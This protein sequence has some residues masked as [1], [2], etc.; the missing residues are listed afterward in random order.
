MASPSLLPVA[1]PFPPPRSLG[2]TNVLH[3]S[4]FQ[5]GFYFPT[6]IPVEPGSSKDREL[7]YPRRAPLPASFSSLPTFSGRHRAIFCKFLMLELSK[8][9]AG[10]IRVPPLSRDFPTFFPFFMLFQA[11]IRMASSVRGVF[12]PTYCNF[13]IGFERATLMASLLFSDI[14]L[15]ATFAPPP[16]RRFRLS[17]YDINRHGCGFA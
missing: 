14:L 17:E 11:L 16:T 8:R 15:P 9:G 2:L 3:P 5:K 7:R 4:V 13:S 6:A 1:P 10:G 12:T